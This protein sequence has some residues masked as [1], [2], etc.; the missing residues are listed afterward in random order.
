MGFVMKK[1]L[2]VVLII[3]MVSVAY[4]DLDVK[5]L[6]NGVTV[7]YLRVDGVSPKK[8]D[9]ESKHMSIMMY[10]LNIE[11]IDLE[12]VYLW[13]STLNEKVGTVKNSRFSM[14]WLMFSVILEES[15]YIKQD[16]KYEFRLKQVDYTYEYKYDIE[17]ETVG[18]V[19]I[20]SNLQPQV[21]QLIKLYTWDVNR[22]ALESATYFLKTLN[23]EQIGSGT[24]V[25]ND[26]SDYIEFKLDDI[27]NKYDRF[28][29]TSDSTK[30]TL[31]MSWKFDY[32]YLTVATLA[33]LYDFNGELLEYSRDHLNEYYIEFV[34]RN[35]DPELMTSIHFK[36][37]SFYNAYTATDVLTSDKV[38]IIYERISDYEEKILFIIDKDYLKP[39]SYR[40]GFNM[41]NRQ[42]EST[43]HFTADDIDNYSFNRAYEPTNNI[44]ELSNNY[45]KQVFNDTFGLILDDTFEDIVSV[46]MLY[47]NDVVDLYSIYSDASSRISK[48]EI[49]S[50]D[51]IKREIVSS[52][53]ALKDRDYRDRAPLRLYA[54]NQTDITNGGG[55]Y[56]FYHYDYV[57]SQ[58][59]M[60]E[61]TFDYEE[62]HY[63]TDLEELG[64]YVLVRE[65]KTF[66]DIE[67]HWA[68][69][70]IETMYNQDRVSGFNELFRPDDTITKAQFVTILINNMQ[71]NSIDTSLPYIDVLEDDWYYDYIYKAYS[72]GLLEESDTFNPNQPITRVEMALMIGKAYELYQSSPND[73]LEMVFTDCDHLSDVEKNYIRLNKHFGIINGYNDLTFRPNSQ[74]TRAE[75]SVMIWKLIS[76]ID[77]K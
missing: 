30:F 57:N 19:L 37:S 35:L 60:V 44:L 46:N 43:R 66:N 55:S 53:I 73:V 1:S 67:K 15:E 28:M 5:D 38:E 72:R 8:L 23:G 34:G 40:V 39:Q 16:H 27:P 76:E 74:A 61:T 2:I 65:F 26:N 62:N 47:Y 25:R 13:D 42:V 54:N 21:N 22:Q 33:E 24:F 4:G 17:V 20:E 64:L 77:D 75:G 29:I 56:N 49:N 3:L 52:I 32:D 6:S 10:G 9:I 71:L 11:N 63:Y 36:G 69:S 68:K 48:P 18:K 50:G 7:D 59:H 41:N 31:E 45:N 51:T 14:E 58:W 70:V 12:S